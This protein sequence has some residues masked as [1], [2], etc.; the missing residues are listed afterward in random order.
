MAETKSEKDHDELKDL[1]FKDKRGGIKYD[2]N[3]L[4]R[5]KVSWKALSCVVG[6]IIAASGILY[7]YQWSSKDALAK[8]Y[9]K[10]VET[11]TE[12]IAENAKV[13]HTILTQQE[14]ISTNIEWIKESLERIEKSK[15][16]NGD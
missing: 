1:L 9:I 11:N 4:D 12:N 2:I 10:M 7:G 14:G 6:L 8:T 5:K 13:V 15:K 16:F 3:A